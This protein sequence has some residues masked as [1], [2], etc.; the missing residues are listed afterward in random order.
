MVSIV[1]STCVRAAATGRPPALVDQHRD[2]VG[3]FDVQGR[4]GPHVVRSRG[5]VHPGVAEVDIGVVAQRLGLLGDGGDEGHG[6]RGGRPVGGE[7]QRAEQQAP[8]GSAG[9][10]L[11]P[12]ELDQLGGRGRGRRPLVGLVDLVPV[13]ERPARLRAPLE[14]HHGGVA[15]A[16]A[17]DLGEVDATDA[18][19]D[20]HPQRRPVADQ[21]GGVVPGGRDLADGRVVAVE[22]VDG[23]VSPGHL[24]GPVA[25]AP[26]AQRTHVPLPQRRHLVLAGLDL[27]Q[28]AQHG[29]VQPAVGG[30]GRDGLLG[31]DQV[32]GVH[33]VHPVAGQALDEG[34]GLGEP[35]GV[36]IGAGTAV[37][38][39][40]ATLLGVR[41]WRTR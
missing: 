8:P 2:P 40:R 38:R 11:G 7:V 29:H 12:R 19:G 37:S 33:G 28:A 35:D 41:P 9:G 23:V 13:H 17:D 10:R 36:Q 6:V 18:R 26:G 15:Q 27:A 25:L 32:G 39:R 34:V 14:R 1:I 4:D 5:E 31:A 24:R 21:Q 3:Q 30:Q 22:E 16:A 20:P